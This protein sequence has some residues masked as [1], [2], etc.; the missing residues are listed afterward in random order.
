MT[1]TIK[2]GFSTY[3]NDSLT[4]SEVRWW[5]RRPERRSKGESP[6]LCP[7]DLMFF[8][9]PHS[10][11]RSTETIEVSMCKSSNV[12]SSTFYSLGHRKISTVNFDQIYHHSYTSTLPPKLNKSKSKDT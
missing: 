12:R 3:I 9:F 11:S 2:C 6:S 4:C 5:E 8:W 7:L 10:Y 1:K